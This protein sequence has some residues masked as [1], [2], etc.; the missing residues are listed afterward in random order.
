MR[1]NALKKVL[2]AIVASR[3]EAAALGDDAGAERFTP[4]KSLAQFSLTL[5]PRKPQ[6]NA[7]A[8]AT[9]TRF[10]ELLDDDMDR[11]RDFVT[12]TLSRLKDDVASC[13]AEIDD[14][15]RC[16]ARHADLARLCAFPSR[17]VVVRLFYSVVVVASLASPLRPPIHRSSSHVIDR[18]STGA[19]SRRSRRRAGRRPPRSRRSSTCPPS[20]PLPPRRAARTGPGP[21]RRRAAKTRTRGRPSARSAATWSRKRRASSTRCENACSASRTSSFASRSLRT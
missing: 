6:G 10:F 2:K 9:E 4:P 15:V 1:Y 17:L 16:D 21:R 13:A 7:S 12:S 19:T 11:V 3:D 5:S 8:Q 14:A 20:S 18:S